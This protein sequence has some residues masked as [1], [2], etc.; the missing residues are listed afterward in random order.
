[1]NNYK[2]FGSDGNGGFIKGIT[3]NKYSSK[4]EAIKKEI[5][6]SVHRVISCEISLP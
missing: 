2:Y 5:I 6:Y 4:E 3:K 1:M